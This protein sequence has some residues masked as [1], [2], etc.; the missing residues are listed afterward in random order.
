MEDYKRDSCLLPCSC[1]C[2]M[3]VS[4]EELCNSS[5]LSALPVLSARLAPNGQLVLR[6]KVMDESRIW[7]RVSTVCMCVYLC[8]YIILLIGKIVSVHFVRCTEQLV[9]LFSI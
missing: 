5:C 7:S 1:H 4:V 2:E 9:S 6:I 3:Y 8:I